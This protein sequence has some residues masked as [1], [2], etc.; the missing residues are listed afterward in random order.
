MA[1]ALHRGHYASRRTAIVDEPMR[2]LT[3]HPWFGPKK[4]IGWGLTIYTWQGAVL[5]LAAVVLVVASV[6]LLRPLAVGVIGAACVLVAYIAAAFLTG[7]PP[8]GRTSSK[9]S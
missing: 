9:S 2:R 1:N 7:D 3:K 8:G 5:T 6:V 4:Y